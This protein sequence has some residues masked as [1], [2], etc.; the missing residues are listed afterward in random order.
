MFKSVVP[1]WAKN[2]V[3]ASANLECAQ[4]WELG[5]KGLGTRH[6]A[7]AVGPVPGLLGSL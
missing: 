1:E 3:R 6:T 5:T 7:A 2:V 4:Y